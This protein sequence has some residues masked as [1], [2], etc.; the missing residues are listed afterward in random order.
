MLSQRRPAL[1]MTHTSPNLIGL[2]PD[3][4]DGRDDIWTR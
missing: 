1:E 4:T 3:N 2:Q